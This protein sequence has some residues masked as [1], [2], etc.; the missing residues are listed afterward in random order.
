[1]STPLTLISANTPAARCLANAEL[2][3]LMGLTKTAL[4]S[5]VKP[6]WERKADAASACAAAAD[7][8]ARA[9]GP[10]A[11]V[12]SVSSSC[13]AASATAAADRFIPTR[14]AT[15]SADTAL[16][17]SQLTKRDDGEDCAP[18]AASADS[19][20]ALE[21]RNQALRSG[22]L[23]GVASG[24]NDASDSSHRILS[25]KAKPAPPPEGHVN[26]LRVLYSAGQAGGADGAR[27]AGKVRRHIA[28]A[29]TRILDAPD[30]V[31]DYY[32]NLLDWSSTNTLAVALGPTIYLWDAATGGINEL[33]TLE[34]DEE[35]YVCSLS[36]MNGGSHIAVGTSAA[37]TQLWDVAAQK[38]V[39]AMNGHSGRVSSL[40]WNNHTLSS[41]SR[42][43]TIVNHDVRARE[44]KTAT[45]CGHTQEV[46]GL[47]WS[48]D[49]RRL[50]SGANDNLLCLWD[51]GCAG[52]AVAPKFQLAGHSAAVKALAWS[53]HDSTTLATGGGT[54]DR[55]I[56]FWNAQTGACLNSIDT[57][58]QVC[59]LQWN[60]H[61]KEI[62]SSHGFS[63]NELN[64]W[65]YP[66]MTKVKT[67]TGHS[68]RALHLAT[69]PDGA[70]CVS[71]GADETLR[72]WNVFGDGGK[73]KKAF[74]ASTGGSRLGRA[75]R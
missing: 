59:A 74:A 42:D 27:R 17:R 51:A 6:R 71:A 21:T 35:E 5:S 4:K 68:S 15:F 38:Q 75:I 10:T 62:L 7:A 24:A 47:K 36:F 60:P 65:S 73:S 30:L 9:A 18:E 56:K 40:S 48:P 28:S 22:L 54:A 2:D 13:A 37:S 61:S 12:A 64:L 72:F 29:P 52:N 14:S 16:S 50:A 25:F 11:P 58:S 26:S 53:P 67:L 55:S 3:G 34:N 19:A 32:L 49:G 41:G 69:S 45:L 1:M 8:A 46:C 31:D 23:S 66:R 20:A 63:N 57:G 33:M 70:T 43:T 39:R 44:H